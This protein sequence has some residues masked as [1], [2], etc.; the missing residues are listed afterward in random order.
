MENR[1]KK[2]LVFD[3][4]KTILDVFTIIFAESGYEVEISETSHDILERVE[5]FQPDL[6]LMDNWIP[7]IG[8]VQALKLLRKKEEYK[9]IPVIY[10]SANSDI[11]ALAKKAEADD[12][13][14]KPFDL[15]ALENLVEKFLCKN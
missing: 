1:K 15:E 11:S 9:K 5:S 8:G 6:I 4:E 14:A 2:I 13:I 3:D 10:T 12:Y 7:N